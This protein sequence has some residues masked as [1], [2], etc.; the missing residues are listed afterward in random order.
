M[1]A[2]PVRQDDH[3]RALLAN[4]AGNLNAVGVVVLN[5]AIRDVERFAPRHL[6][7]A[8][9]VGRFAGARF[10]R[11]ARS[12]LALREVKDAGA[13]ALRRHLQQRAAAGLLYIVAMRGN[14][15]HVKRGGGHFLRSTRKAAIS[16]RL[17]ALSPKRSSASEAFFTSS[18]AFLIEASIPNSEGYVAF[19]V[20]VSLPAVLPSCSEV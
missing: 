5:P 15:E 2:L 19:S 7:N 1:A 11:A 14:G 8:R 12:K 13:C 18:S 9:C 3:A 10:G 17:P 16:R 4:D 6:Q 20:A